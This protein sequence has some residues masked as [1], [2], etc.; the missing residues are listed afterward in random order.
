M[1]PDI[2]ICDN[3][4]ILK[5]VLRRA[6]IGLVAPKVCALDGSVEDSARY[7]PT[8]KPI[9]KAN[10][11]RQGEYK[12]EHDS[13][14]FYPDWVAGMFIFCSSEFYRRLTGFDEKFFLY[15]EDIDFCLRARKLGSEI[16]LVG[17]ANV[18][19]D[20]QRSSHRDFKLF[21]I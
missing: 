2:R 3:P 9:E 16:A 5:S 7:F 12:F 13:A 21:L 11:Q 8:P 4:S 15:Y 14:I 17:E 18:F 10:I 1:G 20:A 19:H 6:E